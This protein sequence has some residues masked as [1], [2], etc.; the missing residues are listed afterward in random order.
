MRS[1]LIEIFGKDSLQI[2]SFTI[3][4]KG[5]SLVNG[6]GDLLP[7]VPEDFANGPKNAMSYMGKVA[8]LLYARFQK[9]QAS[10]L[11]FQIFS[12]STGIGSPLR[13]FFR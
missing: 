9:S 11:L 5:Y 10:F 6:K 4:E 1:R 2:V 8:A 3:T 7:G 13:T 12:S